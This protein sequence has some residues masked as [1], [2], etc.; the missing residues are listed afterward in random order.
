ME[1]EIDEQLEKFRNLKVQA[2]CKGETITG[3]LIYAAINPLHNQFQLTLG[4][5]PYWPV[6]PKTVKLYIPR[7]KIHDN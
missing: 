7:L 6:D 2:L 4:R 1:F 3:I 5:T